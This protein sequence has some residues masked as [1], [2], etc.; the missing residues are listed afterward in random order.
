VTR[1]AARRTRMPA[2]SPRSPV[3]TRRVARAHRR[4]AASIGERDAGETL[5]YTAGVTETILQ[6]I[7]TSS[8]CQN[9]RRLASYSSEVA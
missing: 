8:I 2:I 5:T 6:S 1:R 9:E 7:A 3:S 4:A